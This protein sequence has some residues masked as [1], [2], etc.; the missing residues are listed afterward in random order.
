MVIIDVNLYALLR[1]NANGLID[2]V[3]TFNLNR[4]N[5]YDDLNDDD[6]LTRVTSMVD[7]MDGVL[8]ERIKKLDIDL[9][10][11]RLERKEIFC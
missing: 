6:L 3:F 11:L 4:N 1:C 8:T 7:D 10:V 9:D 2:H 5:D